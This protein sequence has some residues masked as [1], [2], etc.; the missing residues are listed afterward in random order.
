MLLVCDVSK[1]VCELILIELLVVNCCTRR[2]VG[3]MDNILSQMNGNLRRLVLHVK[4]ARNFL[5]V[6]RQVG[7]T[8]QHLADFLPSLSVPYKF[9]VIVLL[10]QT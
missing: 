7:F 8:I 5:T 9:C 1:F 2:L 6:T 3:S 4:L 10:D